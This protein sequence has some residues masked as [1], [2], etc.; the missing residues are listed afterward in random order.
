M[1]WEIN[2]E[3]GM[4]LNA[5]GNMVK[6]HVMDG[7]LSAWLREMGTELPAL[8]QFRGLADELDELIISNKKAIKRN[9]E[10]IKNYGGTD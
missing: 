1:S 7:S 3:M 5:I 2:R 6:G 10:I 8:E 9:K 4:L